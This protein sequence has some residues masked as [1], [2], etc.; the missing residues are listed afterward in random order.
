MFCW[1]TLQQHGSALKKQGI[2]VFAIVVW[3][4]FNDFVAVF[5]HSRACAL[6]KLFDG[7]NAWTAHMEPD[8]WAKARTTEQGSTK[9]IA[10]I[11]TY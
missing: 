1:K 11:S 8:I 3:Q 5:D 9:F 2:L 6:Y 7:L 4:I 10:H